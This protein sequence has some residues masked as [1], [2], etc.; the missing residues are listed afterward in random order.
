MQK[1]FSY[2]SNDGTKAYIADYTNGLV[3]VDIRNPAHPTKLGSY[4][5]TGVIHENV[6]LSSDGTKAYIA[7]YEN[8]LVIVDIS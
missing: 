7:D 2:L 3:I 1:V 6:T 5:T 8:G 4:N